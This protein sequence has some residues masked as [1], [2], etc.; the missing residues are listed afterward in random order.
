MKINIRGLL[1]NRWNCGLGLLVIVTVLAV[2]VY[3]TIRSRVPTADVG[4]NHSLVSPAKTTKL[5]SVETAENQPVMKMPD[6]SRAKFVDGETGAP[7]ITPS[8]ESS[9]TTASMAVAPRQTR[10]A[11]GAA[12]ISEAGPMK[13]PADVPVVRTPAVPGGRFQLP[14]AFQPVN[15]EALT[16]SIQNKLTQLQE[17]FVQAI[18]DS[19]NSADPAFQNRWVNAQIQADMQYRALF[20]QMAFEEMQVQQAQSA[21]TRA[22]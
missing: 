15:P 10:S 3:T 1:A 7:G 17:Q 6:S 5:P 11:S 21:A 14:L 20:G 9:E 18:G 19:Q 4:Q 12:G 16:P 8:S 22:Q 2:M 13:P